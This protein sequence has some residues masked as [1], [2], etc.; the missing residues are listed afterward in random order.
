VIT[1][2]GLFCG[3]GGS[4][5][6]FA[7]VSATSVDPRGVRGGQ[8]LR[9]ATTT[10]SPGGPDQRDARSAASPD[11]RTGYR[12]PTLVS[13]GREP[14][15]SDGPAG[16]ARS[17][18]PAVGQTSRGARLRLRASTSRRSASMSGGT[19]I[20]SENAAWVPQLFTR[21][22]GVRNSTS[23]DSSLGEGEGAARGARLG[24]PLAVGVRAVRGACSTNRA[25]RSR[26]RARVG[27]NGSG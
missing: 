23:H 6:T 7:R 4:G 24:I 11:P 16:Q 9:S 22:G 27:M 12:T 21:T 13:Q 25:V 15:G 14:W 8:E 3:T 19:P 17:D 1:I 2:A 26:T 18:R 10:P 5:L 20:G